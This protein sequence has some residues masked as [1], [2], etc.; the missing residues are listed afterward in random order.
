MELLA[1]EASEFVGQS[2]HVCSEVALTE[3]EYFPGSQSLQMSAPDAAVYFP[4]SQLLQVPPLAPENPA[5]QTQA[6]I[7]LLPAEASEFTGQFSHFLSV[8]APPVLEYLPD[9][10]ST[11]LAFPLPALYMPAA[12]AVHDPPPPAP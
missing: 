11:Q 6:V 10:Q 8:V 12:H 2:W 4:V 1:A 9:S 7:M 3:S 5:L